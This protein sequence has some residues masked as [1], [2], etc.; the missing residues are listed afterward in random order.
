[1]TLSCND[2][3][4]RETCFFRCNQQLSRQLQRTSP[5][6][7]DYRIIFAQTWASAASEYKGFE[8]RY[9]GTEDGL[10]RQGIT[11]TPMVSEP[12]EALA[13]SDQRCERASKDSTAATS[14]LTL[15]LLLPGSPRLKTAVE[16][17]VRRLLYFNRAG[18]GRVEHFV[19]QPNFLRLTS[20]GSLSS[21]R[22]IS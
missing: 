10:A 5:Q 19:T 6:C 1:M 8:R 12:S 2:D 22:R 18:W 21:V 4:F 3:N 15:L 14:L 11:F 13:R 17:P 20:S 9:L 7:A 16:L